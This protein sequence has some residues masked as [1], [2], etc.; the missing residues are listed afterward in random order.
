MPCSRPEGEPAVRLENALVLRHCQNRDVQRGVDGW[1]DVR[2]GVQVGEAPV[3][4]GSRVVGM[5]RG[6]VVP[7][8]L[9]RQ[10]TRRAFL[11]RRRKPPPVGCAAGRPH[12]G[13]T[14][15]RAPFDGEWGVAK[16]FP[17]RAQGGGRAWRAALRAR[18][19]TSFRLT[20]SAGQCLGGRGRCRAAASRKAGLSA[21]APCM[22]AAPL[23][24]HL[25]HHAVLLCLG[26][27]LRLVL[28]VRVGSGIELHRIR[29]R[30]RRG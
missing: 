19:K 9:L 6:A 29:C 27:R 20:R 21:H 2:G 11:L 4:R 26:Q 14:Q 17:L 1:Q 23:R 5:A 12:G 3:P 30:R 15:P 24:A 7:A 10:P 28:H 25:T 16:R 22:N 18:L 13:R 8:A